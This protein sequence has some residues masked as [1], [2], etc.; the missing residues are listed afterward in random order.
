MN[1]EER[2]QLKK[3]IA[4]TKKIIRSHHSK[5]N[6]EAIWLFLA[7]IACWSIDQAIP[8]FIALALVLVFFMTIVLKGVDIKTSFP[9]MI[10]IVKKPLLDVKQ[11][12]WYKA[13]MFEVQQLKKE[14]GLI[15]TLRTWRFIISLIFWGITVFYFLTKKFPMV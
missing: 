11:D 8:A 5:L 9:K 6:T 4:K 14:I 15:G 7:T 10:N 12:D 3:E 13:R 2:K 1:K